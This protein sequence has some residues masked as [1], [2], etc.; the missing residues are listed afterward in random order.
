M[1]DDAEDAHD[2]GIE[3]PTDRQGRQD[4]RVGAGASAD[5]L[6]AEIFARDPKAR[7]D[8]D[9]SEPRRRLADALLAARKRAG[10]SQL[11]V[12]RSADWNQTHVARME[13]ATGPWPTRGSLNSYIRACDP[14]ATV[15]LVIAHAE[16]EFVQ[17][18][19]AVA[20]GNQAIDRSLETLT[21]ARLAEPVAKAA[22]AAGPQAAKSGK[23]RHAKRD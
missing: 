2:S 9:R 16:G 3:T 22:A 5:A 10:L 6:R 15:G 7:E 4:R 21:N 8:W 1:I 20:F 11:D 17:I 23:M 13:S 14:S 19:A 18:D 12:A